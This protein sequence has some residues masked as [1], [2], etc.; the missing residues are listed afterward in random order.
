M[1]SKKHTKITAMALCGMMGL[2]AFGFAAGS[3]EASSHH[4]SK[5]HH[6]YEAQHREHPHPDV[7]FHANE[8]HLVEMS[9]KSHKKKYSEGERNTAALVGAVVGAIIAKNT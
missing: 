3:A 8:S 6:H 7:R 5:P 9:H 4:S 1:F 2:S